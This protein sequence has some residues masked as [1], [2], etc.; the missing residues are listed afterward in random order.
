VT[1]TLSSTAPA[2]AIIGAGMGG[3]GGG[4]GGGGAPPWVVV[5]IGQQA[6][7]IGLVSAGW[8]IDRHPRQ[9]AGHGLGRGVDEAGVAA[10]DQGQPAGEIEGAAIRRDTRDIV[11]LPVHAD[12]Q[13]GQGQLGGRGHGHVDHGRQRRLVRQAG[14]NLVEHQTLGAAGAAQGL[15]AGGGL[16]A[17]RRWGLAERW[18]FRRFGGP[19]LALVRTMPTGWF[20]DRSSRV[21]GLSRA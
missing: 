7:V 14:G 6:R 12:G 1:T 5:S 17:Q 3:D 18:R 11:G 13:V 8:D 21:P 10:V 9:L 19:V 4:G 16:Q 15:D 20:S 2:M